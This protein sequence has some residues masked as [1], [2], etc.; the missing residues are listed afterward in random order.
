MANANE[1]VLLLLPTSTYRASDF[2]AAADRLGVDV[3]VASE[4]ASTMEALSPGSL[5]T[6]PFREPEACAAAAVR[7]HERYPLSA[8]VGVDEET[9]VVASRIAKAI[10]LPAN[11][12]E[13][14]E[15]ARRK[16][17]M[18]RALAAKD[19]A[20]PRFR[21]FE[22]DD[23]ASSV[24]EWIRYPAVIKPVFLSASRGVVRVDDA[25]SFEKRRRWL[26]E[27]LST[28]ELREKGG[29]LA[30]LALV[31]EFVPG[32]EVA[33]EALLT[34]GELRALALFDKPDPLDGPFFEETLYVT[35]SRLPENRQREILD[36]TARA[37]R[38]LGL[39]H[40]PVHAE[41]RLPPS[42]EPVVI[43]VAGRSIGGL[44]SRALRFGLGLSL[45]ELILRH[46][47]GEDVAGEHREGGAS[48]VMM[49]PIPRRGRLEDVRGLEAARSV[50]G[51]VEVTLTAPLGKEIV[52]LPEGSSYLGFAF[53]RGETPE[54]VERALRRAQRE[55]E[56]VIT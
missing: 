7:F 50:A 40:G 26:R 4:Q 21:V 45:E 1:R 36:T 29:P 25:R 39:R 35:P 24:A 5:L 53:A 10:G 42:R 34:D 2:L 48:G 43:E 27:W 8:V 12:P 30:R 14:A 22:L 18:R 11:A 16:D 3:V 15:R 31:E 55:L 38:A 19:V 33:V 20:V 56:L 47:L 28:P 44:C 17:E 32:D 9:V 23:D 52:P 51:V 46:A 6:L 13:A 37:A 54:A 49:L 41:L